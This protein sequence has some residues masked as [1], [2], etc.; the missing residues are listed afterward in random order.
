MESKVKC[1]VRAGV[2]SPVALSQVLLAQG[3]GSDTIESEVE[4]V[5]RILS[6]RYVA[7]RDAL[8]DVSASLL[9][10]LPFNSGCFH[11]HWDFLP[12]WMEAMVPHSPPFL[13][14]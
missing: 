10:P 12:L 14:P 3:I 5:R 4:E 7:L 9:R 6:M 13:L 8:A 1:L 11:T 2:G